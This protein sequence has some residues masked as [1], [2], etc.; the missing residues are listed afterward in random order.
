MSDAE[1]RVHWA[2][3][4]SNPQVLNDFIENL[5]VQDS[6]CFG[7][8]YGLDDEL[9]SFVPRPCYAIIFLF[10]VNSVSNDQRISIA[11]ENCDINSLPQDKIKPYFINQTISN[12]CGAIAV[13]HSIANNLDYIK[14]D[15]GTLSKFIQKTKNLSSLDKGRALETDS[16][17]ARSNSNSAVQGQTAAI[18]P[19]EPVDLHFVSFVLNDGYLVELDGR[20]EKPLVHGIS[21][22]LLADA[23]KVI[24]KY[25]SLNPDEPNFSILSL[26]LSES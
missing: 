5:G 11:Q 18:N 15:S 13:I 14:L 9:L 3:L 2:P 1:K 10:P 25:M 17:F 26:S 24:K 12:A 8:V 20:L 6:V 19:E 7:D 21:D 16:D 22:D 23:S 4:E